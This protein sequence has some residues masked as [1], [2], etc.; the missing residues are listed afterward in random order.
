MATIIILIIRRKKKT[1][2][3][4][5]PAK[6]GGPDC[7]LQP[8]IIT[9]KQL[10]HMHC[11][12]PATFLSTGSFKGY[13]INKRE[14]HP[15]REWEA[16]QE[17]LF[18]YELIDWVLRESMRHQG[19]GRFLFGGCMCCLLAYYRRHWWQV[20]VTLLKKKWYETLRKWYWRY[21]LPS[22]LRSLQQLTQRRSI[23]WT[24]R[25]PRRSTR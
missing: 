25:W 16:V 20:C 6:T 21:S 11:G 18:E 9:L 24:A 5:G 13:P 15:S 7:L 23:W 1:M 17:L 22:M 2:L 12:F 19:C 4:T 3:T 8:W 10:D 14:R